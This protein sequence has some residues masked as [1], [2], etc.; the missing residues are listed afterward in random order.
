MR[1]TEPEGAATSE[2]S[3][4]AATGSV[5]NA[6][7][8]LLMF[9]DNPAVR[10]ADVARELGVA[11]STAHRLLTTLERHR[12]A[13]QQVRGGTY[14]PGPA[15]LD[16]GLHALADLDLRSVARPYLEELS[17]KTAESACLLVLEGCEVVVLDFVPGNHRL[18]VVE[19]LGDRAPAHSTAAGKAIL[20]ALD[21]MDFRR[22]YPSETLPK[23]SARAV[24]TRRSLE[25]EL[26]TIR[27][28]GYALNREESGDGSVGIAAAVVH[29]TDGVVGAVSLALPS[30]RLDDDL[31]AD[32]GSSVDEAAH[33]IGA[34]LP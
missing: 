34:R 13:A 29:R 33:R 7:K 19:R 2:P 12:F 21:P 3:G 15:L 10:V 18:R 11:R 5:G 25:R 20:A 27:R 23:A 16:M 1:R 26:D 14:E 24:R 22:L 17:T 31:G 28:E 30:S 32:F 8:I 6:L 4:P 9:R